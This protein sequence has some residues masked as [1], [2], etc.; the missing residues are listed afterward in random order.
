[1]AV[2]KARRL[3]MNPLGLRP[4]FPIKIKRWS[5]RKFFRGVSIAAGVGIL[6]IAFL[7]AW[8]AKDLPSPNKIRSLT[9]V[10][11]TQI[12]DR[13]G[14]PLYQAYGDEKRINVDFKD[15][16]DSVKHATIAVE[17]K[18]FYTNYGFD[19][20]GII[21]GVILRPLTG[22]SVE[23]G[24]T[25][26]Q[27]YVK[28]A[29]LSPE[30]TVD[31]KIKELIL[32]IEITTLYSKDQILNLYL[33]DIPYGSNAYGIEA[34]SETYFN[35]PAK[36]LDLAQA[37]TLASLPQAPSYY[38]PYGSHV[39]ALMQRKNFVLSRME[40]L[41]YISAAEEI[42]AEKQTI[43][44]APRHDS[45]KAPH[46][47]FYVLD[48]LEQQYGSQLVLEGGLKVTTTLDP[49][50]QAAAEQA[51]AD[52]K[53]KL[54]KYNASNAALV[55]IDP[56]TGQILA[57][58][59]SV[60][61][62]DT[63]H[64]GNFNVA[65]APRQPGSSFKPIVYATAFKGTISPATTLWDVTT[66]FNG[67][68]PQDFD[69]KNHGPVSVRSAL[70]RSL[71]IPAVKTI[72]LVGVNNVLQTAKAVG[73]TTLNQTGQYGLSLALGAG[74]VPPLEMAGAYG[75]FADGGV[76]HA[77]SAILKVED[78]KGRIL[79][80]W[81]DSKSTALS[82]EVAY[83]I[84][85]VLSDNNA[86]TPTFGARSPL[87]FSDRPVAA[88]TG[89]SE[90]FRDGWTIGYTPSVATAVWTG[91]NDYSPMAKNVDGVVS[92]GPIFHEFMATYL[93]AKPVEQFQRPSTIVDATVDALSG[94]K[95]TQYSQTI[96]DIFAPWQLPTTTDDVHVA[97]QIN[98]NNGK[99]ATDNTPSDL[100]ET[101]VYTELHSEKPNDPS[102]EQPVLAWAQANG[103]QVSSP[104]TEKDDTPAQAPVT[105]S[106]T[107]PH[108]NSIIEG[109]FDIV[110][111]PASPNPISKV[112]FY[113]DGTLA[114][115]QTN[116]P[117]YIH[118][119][120]DTLSQ[121]NHQMT[122]EAIDSLG[123]KAQASEIFII[124]A[125]TTGPVT[126]ATAQVLGD[127]GN[128]QLSWT[129]PSDPDFVKVNIYRSTTSGQLGPLFNIVDGTPSTTTTV[130]LKDNPPGQIYYFTIR[131]VNQ[132]G[133]EYPS[134]N[135]LVAM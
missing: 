126:N 21:R 119:N 53:P 62:F 128:I 77:P 93:K 90:D 122:A 6:A 47:V 5:W 42:A 80:Q 100:V 41:G 22:H 40:S 108:D 43:T 123:R 54:S 97:A 23:G 110:A 45:I 79:Q 48:Q 29:L 55:S 75:T 94:K 10:Q 65:T 87:Y 19:P 61:Y 112:N 111:D 121:G 52:A 2:K 116:Q 46:F 32:S 131:P 89:T 35:K 27:Q 7:F 68:T 107:S 92:A 105:V 67:Y 134:N 91:N 106:I 73:I 118:Y 99:L 125:K 120:P 130:V 129:N 4:K 113:V 86:R 81:H 96:T 8:Y 44:F 33:N 69:G 28:N 11:A 26:T 25:I 88:K 49:D 20:L 103:Y 58:V 76:Y 115:T 66:N 85:N 117:W 59:G 36:D 102:W 31:R 133:N 98:K 12:L 104:P 1:M 60:D 70:D 34:A 24:S 50:A 71:N 39:D 18:T 82:P 13:N 101:Q 9:P 16:P 124:A 127:T 84:N 56:K 83:E 3:F 30:R 14:N 15:I 57:M 72:A 78:S 38:S 63:T 95:P 109:P 135:Q 114:G 64:D 74:D 132:T 17:D 37:A 51:I